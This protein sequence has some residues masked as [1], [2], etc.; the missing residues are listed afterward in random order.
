MMRRRLSPPWLAT[1]AEAE[2]CRDAAKSS[3]GL[4]PLRSRVLTTKS[5]IIASGKPRKM[6]AMEAPITIFSTASPDFAF[7]STA[8]QSAACRAEK[9]PKAD[10]A[11]ANRSFSS[12]PC[13]VRRVLFTP[14]HDGFRLNRDRALDLWWSMVLRKSGIRFSVS[15][16]SMGASLSHWDSKQTA[17][18][19]RAPIQIAACTFSAPARAPRRLS[20]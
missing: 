4:A 15:C 2:G 8:L 9:T 13:P 17:T 18:L 19:M 14:E 20:Q 10:M 3:G 1:E 5:P 6:S 12:P 16:S 11:P 7:L